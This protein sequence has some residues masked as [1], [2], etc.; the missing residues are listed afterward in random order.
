MQ[1]FKSTKSTWKYLPVEVV[2]VV[3]PSVSACEKNLYLLLYLT[4]TCLTFRSGVHSVNVIR[5]VTPPSGAKR[6]NHS[7]I[8]VELYVYSMLVEDCLIVYEFIYRPP[9][10]S[11]TI[12]E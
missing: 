11:T 3:K 10:S 1:L 6:Q 4:F 7:A 5:Q 9:N 2:I 8:E 12:G